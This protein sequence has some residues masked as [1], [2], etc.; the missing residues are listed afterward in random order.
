MVAGLLVGDDAAL[1]Q[2][3]AVRDAALNIIGV[4]P[5]IEQ[6]RGGEVFDEV[7]CG[8]VEAASPG[9]GLH[10]AALSPLQASGHERASSPPE[11]AP[12]R[13]KTLMVCQRQI[14]GENRGELSEHRGTTEVDHRR[15]R[16]SI[17]DQ[18]PE[19]PVASIPA[20][21]I[22]SPQRGGES[23]PLSRFTALGDHYGAVGPTAK[24]AQKRN[25][26]ALASVVG[27]LL[28]SPS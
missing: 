14:G 6:N 22:P 12:H 7:M 17:G 21:V 15:H 25:G 16:G 10:G 19:R 11:N 23:R 20:G 13:N 27:R 28:H 9:F 5:P 18:Y 1:G 3:P 8:L 26:R 4:E 2:H 24:T